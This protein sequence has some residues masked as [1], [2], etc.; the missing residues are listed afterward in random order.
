MY[1]NDG[2]VTNR[3]PKVRGASETLKDTGNKN[4]LM[5]VCLR[6]VISLPLLKLGNVHWCVTKWRSTCLYFACCTY[7]Q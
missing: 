3:I 5:N 6:N 4:A 1:H 2:G 7:I